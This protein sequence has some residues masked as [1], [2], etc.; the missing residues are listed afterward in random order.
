MPVRWR[1]DPGG[2]PERTAM[3]GWIWTALLAFGTVLGTAGCEGFN[4]MA[5]LRPQLVQEFHAPDAVL[6]LAMDRDLT[7]TLRN[8]FPDIE[9]QATCRRVAEF[10][11]DHFLG[12]GDLNTVRVAF[13][14][15][16]TVVGMR[17]T[18]TR[19][20]C[21]FTREELGEPA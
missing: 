21:S 13:A 9:E 11:R 4:Q 5:A 6:A 3:T 15:Q 2:L 19:I 18:K 8:P 16:R 10:V 20:V 17:M 1:D 12:Y 7:V 14:T